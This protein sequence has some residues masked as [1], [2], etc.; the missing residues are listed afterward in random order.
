MFSSGG[1]VQI[2]GSALLPRLRLANPP[3]GFSSA[4][5]RFGKSRSSGNWE[6]WHSTGPRQTQ[7]QKNGFHPLPVSGEHAEA[8]AI[9]PR[10]HKDPFD[11]MLIAQSLARNLVLVTSDDFIRQYAVPQLWAR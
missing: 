5:P 8:A 1:T 7:L 11:R 2:V 6:G 4:P 9:L 3:T 10:I